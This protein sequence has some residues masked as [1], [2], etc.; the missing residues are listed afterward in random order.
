MSNTRRTSV[1]TLR[2]NPADADSITAIRKR[3]EDAGTL[4]VDEGGTTLSYRTTDDQAAVQIASAVVGDT[5]A[6]L[7]TGL[8][9][10]RRT[11]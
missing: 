3:I 2:V 8:G 7:T 9:V 1:Y 4:I 10:H 11:V 5:R 6:Q